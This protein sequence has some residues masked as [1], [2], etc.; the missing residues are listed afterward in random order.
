MVSVS[1]QLSKNANRKEGTQ[2]NVLLHVNAILNDFMGQGVSVSESI[3]LMYTKWLAEWTACINKITW[4]WKNGT[5][6]RVS[7]QQQ[8]P[9][10]M[11][12]I[13]DRTDKKACIGNKSNDEL[14]GNGW[15]ERVYTLY[16]IIYLYV[17]TKDMLASIQTHTHSTY[18]R[19]QC[20]RRTYK[21]WWLFL[22]YRHR[23][24]HRQYLYF[25]HYLRCVY[26]VHSGAIDNDLSSLWLT[27]KTDRFISNSMQIGNCICMKLSMAV[28][29]CIRARNVTSERRRRQPQQQQR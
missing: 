12:E 15:D 8:N 11:N 23:R 19:L 27:K 26:A 13:G 21:M 24:R 25:I 7:E 2:H 14:N 17:V 29:L 18:T 10:W 3:T 9:K 22:C 5:R 4:I 6:E 20:Q 1:V 16:N 28:C